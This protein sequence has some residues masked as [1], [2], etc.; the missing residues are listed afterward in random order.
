MK[1]GWEMKRL[2]DVCEFQ[3]GLTYSKNDEVEFS[4]NIVL[5]SN[6]VLLSSGQLDF[7]ELRYINQKI[8]IPQNKK[9]KKGSILICT[10]NGSKNHLGKVA[11]IDEDYDYAF[12]GF[13]GLIKPINDLLPKFLYF[14]M[15]SENYKTFISKLS[16]GANINNLKFSDLESFEIPVPP[17]AEQKRIVEKLDT[18]FAALAQAKAHTERNLANAKGVFEGFLEGVFLGEGWKKTI[19]NEICS[20]VQ[21]GTSTKSETTGKVVV[22]RMGNIQNSK[23]DWGNLMYSNEDDEI[24]KYKLSHN[25]IL[26]NRTNSPEH[27]GKSAIYK[28]EQPAI[29]AGYLIRI[30]YKKDLINP[31][32]LNY[33]LNSKIVREYGFSVMISSVNQANINGSKLKKYPINLP[34]LSTQQTLVAQL[35]ALSHETKRLETIYTQKLAAIAELKKSILAQAFSGGL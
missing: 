14:A 17:L 22:L 30:I 7:A 9:V 12:G 35:D 13:M 20:D 31:D 32:F 34:P 10:A 16:D 24:E 23:I 11:L 25:D 3:R 28:G 8:E 15:I 6:N 26:F 5:R 29:F 2:G 27:V 21:Y 1:S 18:V 19:L 4:T 33:Y